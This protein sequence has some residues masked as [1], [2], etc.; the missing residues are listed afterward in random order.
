MAPPAFR[1][2]L[3]DPTVFIAP[4]VVILGDV[5][6]QAQ[7]SVWYN[8]VLRGDTDA[9][10]I[11]RGTN[12]QDLCMLH[13]DAGYPCQIG[14][15]VTVG[16]AAIV[17]GAVV[18]DDVMIGMRAVVMNGARIGSG[19]IV[20]VGA[21]VTEG[22]VVPPGSLVMGVPGKVRRQV[23]DADRDLIRRAAE[24]YIHEAA[25]YRA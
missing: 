8:S 6:I 3:I 4:G 5:A 13:A 2:E 22:V 16:H 21:V 23:N 15:R 19:S 9:I 17:H 24:H 12:I 25:A 14:D 1:S 11:G 20:A 10:R 7:S 18:E